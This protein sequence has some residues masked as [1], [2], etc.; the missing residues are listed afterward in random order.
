MITRALI[1][2]IPRVHIVQSIARSAFIVA[3]LYQE[4][5]GPW[6]YDIG[7][8]VDISQNIT[9]FLSAPDLD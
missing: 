4:L 9:E 6:L 2:H 5:I 7:L 1:E 8:L 3:W